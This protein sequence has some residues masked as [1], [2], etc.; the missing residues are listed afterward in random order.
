[1]VSTGGFNNVR[2]NAY[3]VY[4]PTLGSLGGYQILDAANGFTHVGGAT[5]AY[6]TLTN[7]YP[8]IQSGNAF[9][10][11]PGSSGAGSVTFTEA[12]KSTS[13]KLVN[14]TY[15]SIDSVKMNATLYLPGNKVADGNVVFFGSSYSNIVDSNDVLKFPNF[16]ENFF[17]LQDSGSYIVA[18][19]DLIGS[20]DSIFYSFSNLVPD[21][22]KLTFGPSNIAEVGL[23]AI[24]IDNYAD[25]SFAISLTTDTEITFVVDSNTNS[26]QGRFTLVFSRSARPGIDMASEQ[27]FRKVFPNPVTDKEFFVELNN[28]LS[29]NCNIQVV[30]STGQVVFKQIVSKVEN[31]KTIKVNLDHKLPS[32]IYHVILTDEKGKKTTQHIVVR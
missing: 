15:R 18:K 17:I 7:Q 32:G 12:V 29:G 25:T 31:K 4:D 16:G 1:M 26:L 6:Y 20:S 27:T 21:T 3:R 30:N 8:H 5:T 23:S 28:E 24:L 19:R 9:F 11:S 10:I 14:R 2:S 13:Q 22:Y